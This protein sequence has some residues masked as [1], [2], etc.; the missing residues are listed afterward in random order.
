MTLG[1]G[2]ALIVLM[3]ALWPVLITNAFDQA[4]RFSVDRPT[5]EL[6][7]LPLP[8]QERLSFKNAIDILGTRIADAVGAVVYGILTVGFL[9]IHGIGLDLRGTAM[10]NLVLIAAWI[11]G[12]VAAAVGLRAHDSGEHPSPSHGHRTDLLGRARTLGR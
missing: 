2:S 7:Y 3:P 10:L 12:R 5:Y 6:L 4:F 1:F 9:M 8:P 11:D